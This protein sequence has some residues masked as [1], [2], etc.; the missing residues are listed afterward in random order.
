MIAIFL[1]H[2]KRIAQRLGEKFQNHV[3]R[4]FGRRYSYRRVVE[5]P[6]GRQRLKK[7]MVRS[8]Q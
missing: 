5:A 1:A 6:R 4:G 7:F 2:D 8:D 3:L